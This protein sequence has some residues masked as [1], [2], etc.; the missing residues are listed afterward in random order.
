MTSAHP[1]VGKLSTENLPD[2]DD[3]LA[4]LERETQLLQGEHGR[5]L[6][7]AVFP[8]FLIDTVDYPELERVI[9]RAEK[10]VA[11][12]GTDAVPLVLA[13]L[14]DSDIKGHVHLVRTLILIGMPAVPQIIAYHDA[15]TDPLN[16]AFALYALSK[17][18]DPGIA[19]AIPLVIKD[20][21]SKHVELRDTAT[22]SLGKI[23][24]VVS[25][26][27]VSHELKTEMAET[28]LARTTDPIPGVRAKALRT[29]GKLSRFGFLTEEQ[30]AQTR[31]CLEKA[32]GRLGTDAP[33]RAFIVR[34]EAEIAL[35]HLS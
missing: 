14:N 33:D 9:R 16:R 25:P 4:A 26:V 28:T 1:I 32:L 31:R 13:Q 24:E 34:R 12:V 17:M 11:S 15:C 7:A 20:M 35:A 23:V 22:R 29:F 3:G 21:S 6:L 19:Q 27:Q 2:I 30:S 18:A 10:L 5:E 8:L